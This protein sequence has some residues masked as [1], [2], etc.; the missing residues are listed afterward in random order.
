MSDDSAGEIDRET[1]MAKWAEM[2]PLIEH[3]TVRI[4]TP[5]EFVVGPG[6]ALAAD[7]SASKPYHVSHC[8]LACLT[9]GVDHLHALK[10]LVIDNGLLHTGADYSLVRG[11][12]ENLGTAFWVL[13]PAEPTE[14]IARALRWMAQNFRDK[15]KC[16]EALGRDAGPS[17]TANLAKVQ[18]VAKN[19]GCG[20]TPEGYSSTEV[21][22][23]ARAH[24][25]T[26]PFPEW[27]IC[28]G[29]A[30]GRP[31]ATLGMSVQE[32]QP[33][34]QGQEA[35][36]VS[37]RLTSDYDRLLSV[38]LPAFH[39]MTDVLKRFDHLSKAE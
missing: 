25:V 38:T 8:A 1:V 32:P 20:Q 18:R 5:N 28:S 30:H 23:Y 34:Q 19:A 36:V 9:A 16:D 22:K 37:V 15:A 27:Q 17:R 11:A 14:R 21:L 2:A 35:G 12:L 39:L 13:H 31:W 7:D 10:R 24:A 6:S 3:M 29:F 33:A 4:Q 26:D